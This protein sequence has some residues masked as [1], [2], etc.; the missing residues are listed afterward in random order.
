MLSRRDIISP[1]EF[2]TL[3][4]GEGLEPEEIGRRMG[5]S[6]KTVYSKKHKIPQP[7]RG[8]P[9]GAKARGVTMT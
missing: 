2:I 8:A 1:L 4:Y 7:P 5:I 3:Y 6:V 9:R